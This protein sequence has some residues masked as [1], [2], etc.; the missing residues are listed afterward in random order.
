MNFDNI[1]NL[2]NCQQWQECEQEIYKLNQKEERNLLYFLYSNKEYL[3]PGLFSF[4]LDCI[5]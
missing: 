3:N 5:Y 4:V 1:I 2:Y